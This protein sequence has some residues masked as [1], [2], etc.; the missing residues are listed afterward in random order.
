MIMTVSYVFEIIKE[1][2]DE[3]N[4]MTKDRLLEIFRVEIPRI[5]DVFNVPE[6]T[7]VGYDYKYEVEIGEIGL[8]M[9]WPF[10]KI[11]PKL[12]Q[13]EEVLN[14]IIKVFNNENYGKGR[15]SFFYIL[16]E[17]KLDQLFVEQLI[18][19]PDFFSKPRMQYV[20]IYGLTKRRIRGFEKDV[21]TIFKTLNKR[22]D[23]ADFYNIC[24]KY[25]NDTEKYKRHYS[26]I[27]TK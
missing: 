1:M 10:K 21:D 23:G 20:I 4:I 22:K 11:F 25:L 27:I 9:S 7:Y 13:D 5:R 17:M 26:E 14:E 6:H 16:I 12:I 24:A 2:H 3:K 19:H 15:G 18:N 8:N